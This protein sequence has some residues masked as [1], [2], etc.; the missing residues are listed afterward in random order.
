MTVPEMPKGVD[1]DLPVFIGK[2]HLRLTQAVED[3]SIKNFDQDVVEMV[4]ESL[5]G[6]NFFEWWNENTE[7]FSE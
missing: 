6:V 2:I 4:M 7:D 3:R 1:I 5:Y